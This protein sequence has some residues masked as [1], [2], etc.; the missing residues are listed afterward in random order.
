MGTDNN[1]DDDYINSTWQGSTWSSDGVNT[2]GSGAYTSTYSSQESQKAAANNMAFVKQNIEENLVA[3]SFIFMA[4]ALAITAFSALYVYNSPRLMVNIIYNPSLL[5]GLIVT[6]LMIVV[7]A[8]FAV[9]KNSI[10]ASAILFTLYSVINGVTLSFIF[11]MYTT[12]SI[13]SIFFVA[14]GIFGVMAVY[15]LVTKRDLTSLGS[16]LFMALL[17]II[18]VSVVNMFMGNAMVDTV[19]S[20]VCVLVFIGITAY[21]TQKIKRLSAYSNT[22][23]ITCLALMGALEIYL[24]FINIFLRLLSLFGKRK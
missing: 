15:G 6:E 24:D 3:Q 12:A 8:N 17:G 9:K 13:V 22:E 18:V 14:A 23:N 11:L 5:Y 7:A 2:T 20:A 19:V 1:N 10:V 21:D 16:F 4:I